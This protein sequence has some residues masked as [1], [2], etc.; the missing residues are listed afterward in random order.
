MRRCT[1]EAADAISAPHSEGD[2]PSSSGTQLDSTSG[3]KRIRLNTVHITVAASMLARLTKPEDPLQ[4][5]NTTCLP[6]NLN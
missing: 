6:E 5:G 2:K 1:A 4:V 3:S